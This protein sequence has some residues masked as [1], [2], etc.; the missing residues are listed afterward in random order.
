MT[1]DRLANIIVGAD[2]LIMICFLLALWLIEFLIKIEV[3]RHESFYL[4]S[5][6]FAVQVDN[7]PKVTSTYTLHCLKAELWTHLTEVIKYHPQ[8]HQKLRGCD[9]RQAIEIVDIQFAMAN[10]DNLKALKNILEA[11]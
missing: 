9:F 6:S 3:A 1:R 7:L 4:E 5:K 10:Y 11:S 8:Q 2:S